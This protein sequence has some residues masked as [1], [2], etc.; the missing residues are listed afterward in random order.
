M[1]YDNVE[2]II[3]YGY[4]NINCPQHFKKI[5]L[6]YGQFFDTAVCPYIE[7]YVIPTQKSSASTW[8]TMIWLLQE[9][10]KWH[11]LSLLC[12]KA[13]AGCC[14]VIILLTHFVF[15]RQLFFEITFLCYLLHE[16]SRKCCGSIYLLS[17][18]KFT[19]LNGFCFYL[20]FSKCR[21]FPNKHLFWEKWN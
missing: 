3:I 19:I 13:S 4:N 9:F 2:Y 17:S 6:C 14:L 1:L 18:M 15:V 21:L 11:L 7:L 5:V 16:I 20:R 8:G 12:L 10:K